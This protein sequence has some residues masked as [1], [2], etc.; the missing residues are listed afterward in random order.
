[1]YRGI[2]NAMIPLLAVGLGG[3]YHNPYWRDDH[4]RYGYDYGYGYGTAA[5][6]LLR[7]AYVGHDRDRHAYR[8]RHRDPDARHHH[9]RDGRRL[10]DRRR[11]EDHERGNR[12]GRR[13]A[14][15][16]RRDRHRVDGTPRYRWHR[17]ER[18][19][20]RAGERRRDIGGR[21]TR[22]QRRKAGDRVHRRHDAPS[23]ERA[24]AQHPRRGHAPKGAH[25]GTHDRRRD[26]RRAHDAERPASGERRRAR[27]ERTDRRAE[28]REWRGTRRYATA[29]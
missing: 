24:V 4:P 6:I 22:P 21:D 23:R 8:P 20:V 25:R 11:L 17:D 14:I 10:S 27:L 16:E 29:P 13:P 26:N 3:C 19:T 2:R 9:D 1:M 28:T 18:R 5:S 12:T 15:G 7:G